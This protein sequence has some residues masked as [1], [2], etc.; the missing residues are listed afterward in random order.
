MDGSSELGNNLVDLVKVKKLR[1]IPRPAT[2]RTATVEP[3]HT[4]K[5]VVENNTIKPAEDS[6]D[7]R[8]STEIQGVT[9]TQTLTKNT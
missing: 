8:S 6:T 5:E 2:P 7:R 9:D 4:L 1:D 3:A